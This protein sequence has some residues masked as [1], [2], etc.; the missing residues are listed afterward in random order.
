MA[1]KTLLQFRSQDQCQLSSQQT[2][3]VYTL[4]TSE[5]EQVLADLMHQ[6]CTR[7]I[8][9]LSCGRKDGKNDQQKQER[10][11]QHERPLDVDA[12]HD[13]DGYDHACQRAPSVEVTEPACS[14]RAYLNESLKHTR[15]SEIW[16]AQQLQK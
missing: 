10:A 3:T 1:A 2:L 6:N 5:T 14:E 4:A 15:R 8:A 12:K 7:H 11:Q 16:C 9:K 13:K